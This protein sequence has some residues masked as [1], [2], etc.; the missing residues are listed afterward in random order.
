MEE[1]AIGRLLDLAKDRGA[2]ITWG[3]DGELYTVAFDG[4]CFCPRC[5]LNGAPYDHH[6]IATTRE[7][8][9][10]ALLNGR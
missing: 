6:G 8:A 2:A 3:R 7:G 4:M 10:F 9:A 1:T 5:G